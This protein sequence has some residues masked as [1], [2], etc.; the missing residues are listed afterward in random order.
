MHDHSIR[1]LYTGREGRATFTVAR[2]SPGMPKS[3]VGKPICDAW[4]VWRQTYGYLPSC[5]ASPPIGWYQIILL[6]D[7]GTCV[8][9]LPRV[10]VN[11]RVAGI[12]THDLSIA[13]PASEP[14]G[15]RTSH[16]GQGK[17]QIIIKNIT[18]SQYRA[19]Y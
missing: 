3:R 18:D 13:S 2:P 11:S 16:V 7:I 6:G 10:A 17:S 14:L 8:N 12:R 5:K 9:N 1:N 19:V 4:P 15:Q